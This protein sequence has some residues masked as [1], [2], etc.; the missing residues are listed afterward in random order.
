MTNGAV[1]ETLTFTTFSGPYTQVQPAATNTTPMSLSLWNPN[2]PTNGGTGP[3]YYSLGSVGLSLSPP[4]GL[5]F[6]FGFTGNTVIAQDN[7]SPP[8]LISPP[9]SFNQIYQDV[10]YSLWLPVAPP[11]YVGIGLVAT[12]AGAAAPATTS[13]GCILQ[14]ADVVAINN[15]VCGGLQ[16]LQQLYNNYGNPVPF[17]IALWSLPYSNCI[18]P[19]FGWIQPGQNGGPPFGSL[20]VGPIYDVNQDYFLTLTSSG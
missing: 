10:S 9:S 3:Y 17:E 20:P 2:L 15:T 19:S 16:Q 13:Y 4:S 1:T 11:G 14:T 7:V 6:A 5:S 18:V 12:P 8:T